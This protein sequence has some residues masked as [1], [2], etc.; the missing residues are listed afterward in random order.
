[1]TTSVRLAPEPP[2]ARAAA[3]LGT[4]PTAFDTAV[5]TRLDR[6]VS[7]S[8]MVK[9]MGAVAVSSSMAALPTAVIVGVLPPPPAA[10]R[11]SQ[12]QEPTDARSPPPAEPTEP[13]LDFDRP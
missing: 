2:S 9:A 1:M 7:A 11:E 3:L 4:S 12:A 5:T 8:P 13:T 6:A 10:A